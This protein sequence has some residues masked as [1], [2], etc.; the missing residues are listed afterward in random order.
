MTK[1]IKNFWV[2]SYI[3]NKSAFFYEIMGFICAVYASMYLAITANDPKMEYIYPLFFIA[4][5][6]SSVANYKRKLAFPLLL[7]IYFCS[8]NIFG[9][10]RALEV[11]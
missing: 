2:D 6:S 7:T 5:Y 8:V 9:F 3:T 10:G 11:W 4:A 1:K